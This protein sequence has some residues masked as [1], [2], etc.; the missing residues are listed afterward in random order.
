MSTTQCHQSGRLSIDDP[1]QSCGLFPRAWRPRSPPTPCAHTSHRSLTRDA[2]PGIREKRHTP[3][4]PNP[5]SS[6]PRSPPQ[7]QREKPKNVRP[8]GASTPRPGP[9]GRSNRRT[10]AARA[11]RVRPRQC[12]TRT[13]THARCREFWRPRPQSLA[14]RTVGGEGSPRPVRL[15]S[16]GWLGLQESGGYAAVAAHARAGGRARGGNWKGKADG[17]LSARLCRPSWGW[18]VTWLVASLAAAAAIPS[19]SRL[20]RDPV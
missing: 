18:L 8:P 20:S 13:P 14:L 4:Q 9:R 19:S 3:T 2:T 6:E 15:D 12:A 7:P 17:W 1:V 11:R 10:R 5:G 16:F